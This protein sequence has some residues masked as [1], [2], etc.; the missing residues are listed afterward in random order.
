VVKDGVVYVPLVAV[1]SHGVAQDVALV[2]DQVK[3]VLALYSIDAG[4][5]ETATVG[6]GRVPGSGITVTFIDF[7]LS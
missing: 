4:L 3:V 1:D 2:E 6:T 5:A 7:L